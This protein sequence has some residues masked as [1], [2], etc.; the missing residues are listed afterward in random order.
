MLIAQSMVGVFLFWSALYLFVPTL[1]LYAQSKTSNLGLVGLA[2]AQ[3]GLWQAIL[4]FP[5]GLTADWLGRRKPFIFLG[6]VLAAL[7][8]WIMHSAGDIGGVAVGRAVTGLAASSWVVLVVAYSGLFDP[9]ESTRAAASL[10][11]VNSLAVGLS[12]LAAGPL[13]GL[14]GYTAG[15]VA[16]I[17]AAGAGL[18]VFL[19]GKE[20]PRPA[21]RPSLSATR[22]LVTR[23]DVLG[24]ALLNGL[25]QYVLFASIYS[26]T[27]ILA[28]QFGATDGQIG[29]LTTVNL[30]AT[31]AGNLLAAVLLRNFGE[32][33]LIYASFGLIALGLG[34]TAAAPSLPWLFASQLL[35]GAAS[36]LGFPTLMGM[37]IVNVAESQRSTAM[38]LHQAVY[39]IGM[40]AGPWLSGLLATP[41]GIQPMFGATALAVLGLGLLGNFVVVRSNK[42][43]R[44]RGTEKNFK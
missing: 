27:P 23:R 15:F 34:L 16:A 25:Q 29:L 2:L 26:F 6:F 10:T 21:V 32:R 33:R 38:G 19:P 36:G 13:T 41:L 18:L 43:P 17:G 28:R 12:S 3:Y 8:A 42:P 14:G 22:Q 37:S 35:V 31:V 1:P 44:H 4:R 9:S 11:L 40:F 5:L 24:P 20:I 7:G 39:G 30:G